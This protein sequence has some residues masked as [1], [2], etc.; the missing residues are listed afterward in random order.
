MKWKDPTGPCIIYYSTTLK[1]FCFW[2]NCDSWWKVDTLQH[3][4]I[5]INIILV[6]TCIW[7]DITGFVFFG[8][9]FL[10]TEIIDLDHLKFY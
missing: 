2:T 3:Y 7:V 9:V 10:Q 4:G 5:A 8:F 6:S 1:M